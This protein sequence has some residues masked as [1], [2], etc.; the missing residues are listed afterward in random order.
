MA[1]ISF[2]SLE[3]SF[4]VCILLLVT[5]ASGTN[6]EILHFLLFSLIG[7]NGVLAEPC[8]MGEIVAVSAQ[9]SSTETYSS[10]TS[11]SSGTDRI[12]GIRGLRCEIRF[13]EKRST[14]SK[15]KILLIVYI[16]RSVPGARRRY[17]ATDMEGMVSTVPLPVL[18]V[19]KQLKHEMEAKPGLIQKNR[20]TSEGI[21]NRFSER[22]S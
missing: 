5:M 19:G 9:N 11:P 13:L 17:A 15:A 16:D 12:P 21:V 10:S 22:R 3:S 7:L 20:K 6:E 8:G 2:P 4:S 14:A 1:R 18:A